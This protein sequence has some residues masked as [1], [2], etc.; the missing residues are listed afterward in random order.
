[1]R[2]K[3]EHKFLLDAVGDGWQVSVTGDEMAA[4]QSQLLTQNS[5]VLLEPIYI[6]SLQNMTLSFQE[7]T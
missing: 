5:F 3:L 6:T 4:N 7:L 2:F 1:M